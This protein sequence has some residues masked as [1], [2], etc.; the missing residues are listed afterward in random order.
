MNMGNVARAQL[1]NAD[2]GRHHLPHR[3]TCLDSRGRRQLP[4]SL[5]HKPGRKAEKRRI[6]KSGG[7]LDETEAGHPRVVCDKLNVSSKASMPASPRARY[8]ILGLWKRVG[9]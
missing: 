4:M 3:V 1:E 8:Q 9:K 6:L 7:Y 2:F 5:D